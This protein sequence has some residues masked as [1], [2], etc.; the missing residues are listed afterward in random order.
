M[1]PSALFFYILACGI[2]LVVVLA[3]P[4]MTLPWWQFS[5][6]LAV[7]LAAFAACFKLDGRSYPWEAGEATSTPTPPRAQRESGR[8]R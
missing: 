7:A 6:A 3:D 2:P 5:A 4:E 1:K 8:L